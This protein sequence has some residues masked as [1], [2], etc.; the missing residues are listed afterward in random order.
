MDPIGKLFFA[1]A[2]IDL[3]NVISFLQIVGVIVLFFLL[4]FL[5]SDGR[6]IK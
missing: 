5:G 3:I 6:V 1:L 4:S 2:S